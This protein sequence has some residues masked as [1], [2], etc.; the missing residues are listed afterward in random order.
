MLTIIMGS[1]EGASINL[2][3]CRKNDKNK[4]ANQVALILD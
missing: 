4:K 3:T 1:Q 2:L